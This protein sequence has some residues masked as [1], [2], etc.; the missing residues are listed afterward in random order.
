[1]SGLPIVMSKLVT[2]EELAKCCG[3]SKASVNYYTNIG[4]FSVS[5]K[6]G[7]KRLYDHDDVAKRIV[8]IR[9]MMKIG[10]TLRLIQR[11]FSLAQN[12]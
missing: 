9:E 4:L 7:N 1:M 6:K 11:E 3:L 10:Y 2:I 5:E 8:K 12:P